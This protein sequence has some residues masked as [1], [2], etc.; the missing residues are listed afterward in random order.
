MRRDIQS[1]EVRARDI[2]ISQ[3]GDVTRILVK[4]TVHNIELEGGQVLEF[5]DPQ[6]ADDTAQYIVEEC[7]Q[8]RREEGDYSDGEFIQDAE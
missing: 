7:I 3:H 2:E 6:E 4:T 1:A 5:S 8:A